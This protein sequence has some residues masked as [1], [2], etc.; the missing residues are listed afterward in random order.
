MGGF[1]AAQVDAAF[2]SGG[3]DGGADGGVDRR[4]RSLLLVNLGHGDPAG[5]YPRNPRLSFDEACRI[6]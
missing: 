2:S 3:A 5:V 4:W 1:D 6:E